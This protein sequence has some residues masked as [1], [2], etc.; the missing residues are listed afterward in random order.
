MHQM[1]DNPLNLNANANSETL[2]SAPTGAAPG[3]QTPP[4]LKN[5]R[6]TS[7]GL[8]AWRAAWRSEGLP[9]RAGA[10]GL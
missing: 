8:E 6:P 7:D 10:G 1:F 5:K 9:W 4:G 2:I 3:S